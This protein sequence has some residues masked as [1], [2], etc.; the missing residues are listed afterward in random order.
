MTKTGGALPRLAAL[1]LLPLLALP[2]RAGQKLLGSDRAV[3]RNAQSGGGELKTGA[4]FA[5]N[6]AAAEVG[7]SSMSGAGLRLYSGLM[8]QL[9]QPGSV[10]ALVAVTKSTG[11]LELSWTAP[12]QDGFEAPV[13]AGFYRVDWSSETSHV[14][15]PTVFQAEFSTAVVPGEL[16]NFT[17][18]GLEPNTTYFVRVYLA[19][20]RKFFAESSDQADESTL[21][22]VPASPV[23][24]GVF[25]TSVTFTWTLP[26]GGAEG[27]GID[28][29][30]TDFG[31]LFPGGVVTSS[32]SADGL[33]VQL[34]ITGLT[35]DTSYFFKLASLN[36]QSEL[37][38]T[39]V[40]AT[41]TLPSGLP[42]P[43]ENLL[44]AAD[45]DNRRV[46][47]SWTNP[48]F[49]NPAGVLVVASTNPISSS[50]SDGTAYAAGFVFPDQSAVKAGA[51]GSSHLE[52]G[53]ELDT[54]HYFRLYSQNVART[55]SVAVSTQL[56][57]D[58]PPMAP[59]GLA[60]ALSVDGTSITLS[61]A[62]VSSN[63]DGSAFKV[64]GAPA[65]WELERFEVWRATGITRSNWVYVG[66][67]PLAATSYV[68]PLPVPGQ[69]WFYK[70]VAKDA[71]PLGGTDA[72]MAAD[73]DGHIYSV[74]PDG[75]SRLKI[76]ASL[77]GVLQPG[78]NPTGSPLLVRAREQ[79]G[80]TGGKVFKSLRFDPVSSPS[81]A[82]A[83]GPKLF[84]SPQLETSLR[85]EVVNG[86][87]VPGGASGPLVAA[88]ASPLSSVPAAAAATQ[89]GLYWHNGVDY[90]KLFGRVDTLEQT[91]AVQ[92]P[93]PG[94]YQ[95][96]GLTRDAAF[97]FDISGISNK[98]ITPNGDGLNDTVVF[99][100]DNPRDSAFSGKVYDTRGGFVADMRTGPVAGA[101]LLWDGKAG[102]GA[103]PQGVY[104][105]K[106]TA[107]G[108]TFTG[109]VVVVR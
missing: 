38:F 13:G 16:Q 82:A 35:P 78:G 39:T 51:A 29:S 37:N 24:A 21:A 25:L 84:A 65:A 5:M 53:L 11:T 27:F 48:A 83:P 56:V 4:G 75:I 66:S 28:G 80:D 3:A 1:L 6:G 73:T 92:S 93:F 69:T 52:V 71:F 58:L 85:Y 59:A 2:A 14:F 98:A 87:V 101:S 47:L 68:D 46:L 77:A 109:T 31:S 106:I 108:R 88:A 9:A 45:P 33:A 74:G 44:L 23:L 96:R 70:V 100:F 72:A 18:T 50:P 104:L 95:I 19:D 61:W 49:P 55:Y 10:T 12:G 60:S 36:W 103:V 67:A 76:P 79:A 22:N 54:T 63:R 34:S 15:A 97:S 102:G 94:S 62:G 30:T 43:I 91:V 99:V 20:E 64:P 41:R 8:H 7:T 57:I 17:A 90:I 42:L 105:Y 89:L 107:E 81:N 32:R 86:Q 40:I 26:A